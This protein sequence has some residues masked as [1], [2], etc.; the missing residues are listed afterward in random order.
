MDALS[1]I[2]RRHDVRLVMVGGAVDPLVGGCIDATA[3][4]AV[5][6]IV[7]ALQLVPVAV[8]LFAAAVT[9]VLLA[10]QT[11]SKTLTLLKVTKLTLKLCL[12]HLAGMAIWEL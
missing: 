11:L 6:M 12:M 7:V 5:A 1:E 10:L 9:M 8:A 4:L 3:V 2:L